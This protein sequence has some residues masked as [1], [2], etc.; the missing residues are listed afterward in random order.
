MCW[1]DNDDEARW[2]G[3]LCCI[4]KKRVKVYEPGSPSLFRLPFS[5]LWID[6]D[7]NVAVPVF[8][9]FLF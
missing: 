1:G 9:F 8:V 5:S 6:A 2:R 7:R 4:K 3:G